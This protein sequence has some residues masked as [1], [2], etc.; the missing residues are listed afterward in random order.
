MELT[1]CLILFGISLACNLILGLLVRRKSRLAAMVQAALTQLELVKS[2]LQIEQSR[3]QE[4]VRQ[5][6][7]QIE[8]FQ[9]DLRTLVNRNQD[10]LQNVA[11]LES[12]KSGLAQ[13]LSEQ[14][15]F[16]SQSGEQLQQ[17]FRGLAS[18]ALESNN[19]VFIDLA[20]QVLGKE[21][22]FQRSDQEKR[23]QN[24][25]LL[26]DPIRQ[27][28]TKYQNFTQEIEIERKKSF[29]SIENELRRVT[30]TNS[31]LS[32]TTAA[33]KDA[34]KRPSVRG[35]WGELQLKNCIELAGMS[36]YS[37]VNLQDVRTSDD[38]QRLIPD[39]TVRMPGGR[40][41]IVDA[42]TPIDAFLGSLEAVDPEIQKAELVRHG[43][44]VKDHVK[45]LSMRAYGETI[46]DSADFTIMFLPNESFLYAALESE[47]D[48]VEFALQR[49]VLIATPPTLVGLLKVI[50]FGWSEEKLAANAQM[51]SEV[52]KEL[53]KRLCDFIEAYSN[54][55]KFLEKARHEYETGLMR[56]E[57]R[58]LGQARRLEKLGAKSHKSL[59]S[60]LTHVDEEAEDVDLVTDLKEEEE[61]SSV[62]LESQQATAVA[63]SNADI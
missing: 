47:P 30:D 62:D 6:T 42:K 41:V 21:T 37:D 28:L 27:T 60:S 13:S 44:H 43:R 1:V 63:P 36:E 12:E 53:H 14:R 19:R 33:L 51:I 9:Q 58:V 3:I 29:V 52:G 17:A 49:K 16:L 45:K 31:A 26:L 56:L 61:A 59:P 4:E 48:L 23:D 57:R 32:R 5:K 38:G 7:S 18:Q 50:R 39:M 34:L 8:N 40:V 10:L 55:G 2:D 35:R 15:S 11:R 24:L 25:Q 54:I 22:Q 20:Q 46:A